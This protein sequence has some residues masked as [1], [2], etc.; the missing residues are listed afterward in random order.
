[1]NK[2]IVF[3]LAAILAGTAMALPAMAKGPG[4]DHDKGGHYQKFDTNGDGY[5]DLDEH[6]AVAKERF[7]KM[8]ANGDGKLTKEEIKES[9]EKFREKMKEWKEKNGK[10]GNDSED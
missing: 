2:Q 1:M 4:K 9:R 8:D 10:R 3:T 6:L 5:I 7:E